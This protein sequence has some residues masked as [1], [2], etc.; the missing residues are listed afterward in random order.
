MSDYDYLIQHLLAKGPL[1][2]SIACTGAGAGLQKMIWDTPGISSILVEANF[3]YAMDA[4]DSFLGFKPEKY[5]EDGMAIAMAMQCYYRAYQSGGAKAIGLGLCASVSSNREHR[6]GHRVHA[7][8]FSDHGCKVF[9]IV[10]PKASDGNPR[11]NDGHAADSLGLQ[12]LFSAVGHLADMGGLPEVLEK[13]GMDLAREIFFTRPY[14]TATGKRL[15]QEEANVEA[16]FPG[17]FNPPHEGHLGMAHVFRKL[18]GLTPTFHMTA[19]T[20][21]KP[22]LT[23]ADMLQRAKLLEGHNRMFTTGDALYLEK[24]TDFPGTPMIIGSDALQR[25]LDPKWGIDPVE[26]GRTF[27]RLGTRFYVTER[28]MSGEATVKVADLDLPEGFEVEVLP[29]RWNISSSELRT[30]SPSSSPSTP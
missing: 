19:E 3:P 22:P 1:R 27:S 15:T 26:L 8:W 13:D 16:I 28:A 17:A 30:T 21:H 24:A 4:S 25:M 12:A 10:L 2:I 18:S 20:P 9:S 14:F 5:C 6:G 7:A 23:L 11:V 29:G